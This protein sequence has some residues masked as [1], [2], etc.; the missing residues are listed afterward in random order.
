L[1]AILA[2]CTMAIVP[3]N[4]ASCEP[5]PGRHVEIADARIWTVELGAGP[6]LVF[7][8]GVPT[9][10]YLWRNVQR[11]LAPRY[12]T[13]A[14][15]LPP[16]GASRGVDHD[17]SLA[18]QADRLAAWADALGLQRFTLVAHDVGGGVAHHFVADHRHR[19]DRLVLVDAVAFAEHWP[20]PI[21]DLLCVPGVGELASL[22]GPHAA[23][24]TQQ[25]RRGLSD[26][27]RLADCTLSRWYEPF[28]A[29]GARL[30]FL[31]FVRAFDP[32]AVEAALARC[33]LDAPPTLVVWGDGDRFQP[34]AAG[35]R[36]HRTLRGSTLQVLP[37]G[38]FLPEEAHDPLAAAIDRFLHD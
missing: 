25:V 29:P 20:V 10:S 19:L 17:L 3:C 32:A 5:L 11:A 12:R 35:E 28:A 9:T 21:I 16:L 24:F 13:L 18:R 30:R 7:V 34:L 31:A 36:L 8:H 1:F 6:P 38:H 23:L 22:L 2:G 15:D 37:A 26:P 27:A 14:I 4:H 33:A